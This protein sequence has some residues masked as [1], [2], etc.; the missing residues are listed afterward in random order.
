[1]PGRPLLVCNL[2]RRSRRP[3]P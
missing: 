3:V 2:K 1:M